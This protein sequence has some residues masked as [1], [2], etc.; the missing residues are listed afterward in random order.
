MIELLKMIWSIFDNDAHRIVSRKGFKK[1]TMDIKPSI[2]LSKI[3]TMTDDERHIFIEQ[4][5]EQV[6]NWL[7][8][9]EYLKTAQYTKAWHEQLNDLMKRFTIAK[10]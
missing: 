5:K 1:L 10:K 2:K 4:H 7:E 9:I 3:S 6:A 8:V